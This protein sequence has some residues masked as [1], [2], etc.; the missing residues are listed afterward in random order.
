M[1]RRVLMA[2]LLVAIVG[3]TARAQRPFPTD[4]LPTRTA[5][6]RLGLERQ[7]YAAVPLSGA[8]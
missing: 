8:R 2:M 1:S 6:A 5:T 7:W 4:L 3:Q